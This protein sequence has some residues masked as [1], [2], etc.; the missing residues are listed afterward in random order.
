MT[1]DEDQVFKVINLVA[2]SP[3]S[4][5]DA[6][7]R[8]VA[9][10]TKTIRDLGN[11]RLRKADVVIRDGVVELY[12]VKL[13]AAFRVD[14]MRTLVGDAWGDITLQRLQSFLAALIDAPALTSNKV[15]R[16]FKPI[17]NANLFSTRVI[18]SK[19][20]RLIDSGALAAERIAAV[21]FTNKAAR[22]MKE[23]V[24]KLLGPNAA[25]GLTVSTFHQLGPKIIRNERKELGTTPLKRGTVF[26]APVRAT[27]QCRHLLAN[28]FLTLPSPRRQRTTS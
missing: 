2:T 3:D 12:R 9:E 6:A 5:E 10:A 26:M 4:W 1:S 11:A 19:I 16:A 23:R 15:I 13:E 20:A 14:R 22:E 24:G 28:S 7:R 25:E 27:R 21:T 17:G 8:G 18:T